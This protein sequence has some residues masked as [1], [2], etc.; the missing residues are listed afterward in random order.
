MLL[1]L[2]GKKSV[3]S[4]VTI[5]VIIMF[6]G[7]SYYWCLVIMCNLRQKET[8]ENQN[9]WPAL[10][11]LSASSEPL[12]CQQLTRSEHEFLGSLG[13]GNMRGFFGCP[14][15]WGTLLGDVWLGRAVQKVL[16]SH[17]LPFSDVPE[18]CSG[19]LMRCI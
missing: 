19:A 1:E 4:E 16:H 7:F 14:T 17:R 5:D 13:F 8:A 18:P 15:G 10:R 9:L 11:P 12:A 6:F 3:F 2:R